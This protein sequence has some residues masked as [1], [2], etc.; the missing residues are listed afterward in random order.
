MARAAVIRL[1]KLLATLSVERRA[2]RRGINPRRAEII[3]AGAYV[4]AELMQ[5]GHLRSFRYS[6]LGLRDGLLAQMLAEH[7]QAARPHK[8][9]ETQRADSILALCRQYRLDMKAAENV[10]RPSLRLFHELRR[11]H[12][13]PAEYE[14]WLSAA[15]LLHDVGRFVNRSGRHRHTYYVIAH[16]ELLG[17]TPE[18]RR[19]IA[20]VARYLGMSRPD[21]DDVPMKDLGD[22]DKEFVPRAVE[23]LRLANAMNHGHGGNITDLVA[24]TDRDRA[25]IKLKAR[26]SPDLELWLLQKERAFFREVF[27]RE[28]GVELR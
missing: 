16:S 21:P 28:L 18:Q 3:V 9:V 14:G 25:V 22:G 11:V 13:L 23:L 19:V 2:K 12:G 20:A 17:F 7:D 15:A 4:Y 10:P 26:R 24:L 27:G 5:R 1:A 8:Q 6:P